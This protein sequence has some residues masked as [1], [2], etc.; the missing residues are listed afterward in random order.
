MIRFLYRVSRKGTPELKNKA[1]CVLSNKDGCVVSRS[2]EAKL[3]GA[4][5]GEPYFMC[6]KE[7]LKAVYP[8]ADHTYYAQVSNMVMSVLKK[9]QPL[10]PDIFYR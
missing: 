3:A 1:V 5:M 2:K 6:K 10:C 9:F 8:I 7:H 4:R